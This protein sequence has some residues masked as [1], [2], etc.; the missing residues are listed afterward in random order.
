MQALVAAELEL[1]DTDL[2]YEPLL[3]IER[4]NGWPAFAAA[5]PTRC[6]SA[7]RTS[8]CSSGR[9]R[10]GRADD[11]LDGW[12]VPAAEAASGR[13]YRRHPRLVG[14]LLRR[15]GRFEFVGL[16]AGIP[17]WLTREPGGKPF[18]HAGV[19]DLT[20][21]LVWRYPALLVGRTE[22]T[23]EPAPTRIDEAREHP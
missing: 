10:R 23:A 18:R 19:R 21:I 5:R 9:R 6:S 15:A 12:V 13:A 17:L 8:T 7:G 1:R 4:T 16:P 2:D 3:L 11:R 20:G 14:H 22:R